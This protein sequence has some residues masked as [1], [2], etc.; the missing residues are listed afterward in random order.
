[1][2]FGR[3]MIRHIAEY[4]AK[5]FVQTSVRVH[6]FHYNII[7]LCTYNTISNIGTQF[8]VFPPSF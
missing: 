4:Y 8:P 6:V 3:Y 5:M 1:M 7:Y 2:H